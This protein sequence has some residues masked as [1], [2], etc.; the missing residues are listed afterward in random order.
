MHEATKA[1]MLVGS[2]SEALYGSYIGNR[3]KQMGLVAEFTAPNEVWATGSLALRA[4]PEVPATS[5]ATG[6]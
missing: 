2:T 5:L 4:F 1:I 6:R 3:P